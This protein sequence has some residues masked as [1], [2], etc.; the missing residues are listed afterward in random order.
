MTVSNAFGQVQAI[1]YDIDDRP[2]SQTDANGVTLTTT[3][4]NL[5]RVV[6]RT[7]PDTGSEGFGYSAFGLLVYTNQLHFTN[8]YAYDAARRKT[9]ETNANWE[10]TQFRYDSSGNLTNLVDGKG[11]STKWNYDQYGRVTNKIDAASNVLFT[12]GYDADNR[13]TGRTNATSAWTAYFYDKDNNLTNVS[14]A[15]NA[16][17]TNTY[18]VLDRRTKMVDGLGS[19]SYA[20]D[21]ASQLLSEGGLW[22]DDTVSFTYQNRLRTGLSLS[23]PDASAW[24]QTYGY[25]L[26]RRLTSLSSPAGSFSHAYDGTRHM[27]V[28]KLTLPNSLYITNIYDSVARLLST[29]LENSGNAALNSHN[30]GYNT[31]NQRTAMTNFAGDFWHTRMTRL[32][33]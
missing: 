32:D 25:D 28:A 10:L 21:A 23:A 26:A 4:D 24:S 7:Y 8:Y 27:Q 16:N 33:S 22:A 5:G 12:Y 15:H 14:Y 13:L 9:F 19:T 29:T 18:D 11:N 30:Y 2:T 31:C 20:Y 1:V 17:I 3:Y 6:A